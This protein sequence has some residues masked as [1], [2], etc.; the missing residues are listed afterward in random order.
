[1]LAATL[2]PVA[3]REK[4][5]AA[6]RRATAVEDIPGFCDDLDDVASRLGRAG[7]GGRR[8]GSLTRSE[9][10][11]FGAGLRAIEVRDAVWIAVDEG[12]LGSEQLWREL[13]RR[14]PSPYD[15][16]PLFLL[17]WTAFR[18]GSGALANI[19]C[20]RALASDPDYSAA[21]LLVVAVS[22]GVD[23]RRLPSLRAA[24]VVADDAPENNAPEDDEVGGG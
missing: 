3:G 24:G 19:A 8:A 13:A 23:P 5:S 6:L 18:T 17:G 20:D 15:A 4:L 7:A 22:R 11:R 1:A 2:D 10:V 21:E 16:A 14:L 12:C 9:V